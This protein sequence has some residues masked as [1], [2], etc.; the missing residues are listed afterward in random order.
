MD[1]HADQLSTNIRQELSKLVP[2]GSTVL[3]AVSGGK[4][5][6]VLSHAASRRTHEP[7][8]VVTSRSPEELQGV[9]HWNFLVAHV[10]HGLRGTHSQKD[11]I[12]VE[13]LAEQLGLPFFCKKAADG[14]IVDQNQGSL[15]ESARQVRYQLLLEMAAEQGAEFVVTAHHR[16]DQA[17]TVLH[18]LVRGS[19]LRGLSGMS[20]A[21]PLGEHCQLLRPL[22]SVSRQQID[23]YAA[24]HQLTW[25]DD[26]TNA[27]RSFTRNRLRH[28]VLPYL[29]T[30]SNR[31]IA[32]SLETIARQ[33]R[34]AISIIDEVAGN[35]LDQ[36]QLE[37]T[38]VS[39]RLSR[40]TL[41]SAS[42]PLIRHML[43][44]L[45]IR[46][47]WPRQKMTSRHW[48]HLSESIVNDT[49]SRRTLPGS[50]QMTLDHNIIRFER[51]NEA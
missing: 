8:E 37:R 26:H 32:N 38:P 28:D 7:E 19:G 29:Q 9:A 39:C 44:L 49:T 6:V 35:L 45:W 16:D 31:D 23:H 43:T 10:D 22:L 25:C 11:R 24:A 33:A 27:D 30:H 40:A 36:C 34:E 48:S 47:C 51:T 50:I 41:Q 1:Q 46:Q 13:S 18:N 20:V 21:R 42:E 17:E 5:S 12:F 4:D 15:E 2:R 3:L 14:S